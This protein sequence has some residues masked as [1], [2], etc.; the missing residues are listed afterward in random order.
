MS[1]AGDIMNPAL[2]S[3][4]NSLPLRSGVVAFAVALLL[5]AAGAASAAPHG[6][7]RGGGMARGGIA[8]GGFA[9]GGF[10]GGIARGGAVRGG[11]ARG[12][13]GRGSFDRGHYRRPY[14]YGPHGYGPHGYGWRPYGGWG[15]GLGLGLYLSTLPWDYA[16]YWWGGVPY[17]YADSNYYVWDGDAEQYEQ[18]QP[19]SQVTQ[20]AA[21]APPQH[22]YAYPKNGQSSE[23]QSRDE[24]ACNT[25]A[26]QQMNGAASAPG[27]TPGTEPPAGSGNAVG[28]I[29]A[30]TGAPP[31]A[32]SSSNAGPN[33]EFLRAEA[34]CLQGRG[35]SVD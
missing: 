27:A 30:A 21:N 32:A 20:Q 13:F 16:T 26:S 28:A 34:A 33:S 1:I 9:R 18:V 23:Q 3:H 2:S 15:L 24:A 31:G 17:Y 22:L 10:R 14:G 11:V 5:A 25:W 35:Y 29:A 8:H 12:G 4:R 7:F 6:G 19:P